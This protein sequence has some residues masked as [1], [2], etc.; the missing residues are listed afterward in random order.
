MSST[1]RFVVYTLACL[2]FTHIMDAMIM[3]PLG[4]IFMR[5]FGINP[6]QFSYIVSAY[7]FAAFLSSFTATFFID[8]FDRKA[9]LIFSYSGFVFGT[10]LCGIAPNY[11]FLLIVR[12]VT[13]LFGGL[14]GAL[15]LSVVSDLFAYERRGKAIGIIM[16]G[17]SAAAALGVPLGLFL[18]ETFNW[19]TPFLFIGGMGTFLL[20]GIVFKFPVMQ[21]HLSGYVQEKPLQV[22][23]N[24]LSDQN[25]INALAL[26][27]ILVLGHFI[28]IP[29]IAPY[30]VRNVGFL[31]SQITWIYFC[32]GILTVFTA[33]LIGKLTDRY[34]PL[35]TFMVVLVL[36][37]V[38]VLWITNM[39]STGVLLGLCATSLF[40]VFG[41]GRMI[42]PQTMITA[43]V[44]PSNRGS[45]M[46][47]KSALQQLS[48]GLATFLSGSIVVF[49]EGD[50]LENY[51]IVGYLSIALCIVSIFI[52]KKLTV[53]EGN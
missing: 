15:V 39:G 41:S 46:S 1:E 2:N 49:G 12:F 17:F 13:G 22:L 14:M 25:Q 23:K 36:S 9:A 44:G 52:A 21:G 33:P 43:A 48:V 20:M 40:F 28:I 30:M 7:A 53:A 32:G 27:M 37:F 34:R 18:A 45:F 26:G 47:M 8:R 29:F 19:N 10:F 31:Q 11:L 24:M 35:P 38:P 50:R 4:D 42:A 6:A 51:D 5:I 3:M 16:A